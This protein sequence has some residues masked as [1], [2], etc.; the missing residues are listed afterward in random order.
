METVRV[1]ILFEDRNILSKS[2][3]KLGL[4]RSWILLKPQQETISDLASYL[5]HI[6]HLHDACPRGIILSMDSFVLPPF[7]STSIFKD[8]DIVRVKNKECTLSEIVMV[9]DEGNHLDLEIVEKQPV[10]TGVQLL[11]ND[12]FQKE[13]GGYESE[14]E[15]DEH[16]ESV[17]AFAVE[18]NP[19]EKKVA[20]KRKASRKLQSS[21]RK[22]NK[23]ATGGKC[24]VVPENTDNHVDAEQNL[25]RQSILPKRCLVKK[26][27]LSV[28]HCEPVKSSTPGVDERSDNNIGKVVPTQEN[29][30]ESGSRRHLKGKQKR[31]CGTPLNVNTGATGMGLLTAYTDCLTRRTNTIRSCQ[32]QENGNGSVD[33]SGTPNGAEKLPS[34]SARRKK[35]KRRWLRELAKAEKEKQH[36]TQL[37][38]KVDMHLPEK[39][40]HELLEE[41]PEFGYCEECPQQDQDSDVEND[42]VPIV[43]RPGHI[44]F[45]PLVDAD[46]VVQQNQIH[47]ETF[48]WNGITSKKKGQKWGKE[49]SASCRRND[50][51]SFSEECPETEK[52][53]QS[54]VSGIE[55]E[56]LKDDCID[57]D[58]LQPLTG[59]PKEGDVIAYRLVELS[60]SWTPELSSLRVG[61]VSRYDPDSNFIM[62]LPFPE[63]PIVVEKKADDDGDASALQSETSLYGEDGSLEIDFS[64][65][66]NISIIKHA[67][68]NSA[69]IVTDEINEVPVGDQVTETSLRSNRNN[70]VAATQENGEVNAWEEISKA[71]NAKK[72]QL[73]QEENS[74]KTEYSG[75]RSMSYK[76]LRSG[77]LG[78]TMALLRAQ[79]GLV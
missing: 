77:A 54:Q 53:P 45:E 27:Q 56:T 11:A 47:M 9:G 44:R 35:A 52:P 1:R 14:S 24:E 12:E 58:K 31:N 13:T 43:V 10:A 64:S 28:L 49:H 15:E 5:L 37:P 19:D 69:K 63:Y 29:H 21:K 76:G 67:N 30:L 32:L 38:E 25:H 61:K 48:Q 40:Y 4:R 75:R 71:L 65:L 36:Q 3:K 78:P 26:D 55:E 23:S 66:V 8:K 62:L 17:D 39:S 72:A 68:S 74:Y 57:F 70:K 34:R 16:E 41:H 6:F 2:Q 51:T 22:K 33:A 50:Y 7:E 59:L 73:P 18:S 79:N 20:K 42:V 46:Q 60:S